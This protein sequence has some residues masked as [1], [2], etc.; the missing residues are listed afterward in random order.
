MITPS[1]PPSE[2]NEAFICQRQTLRVFNKWKVRHI[3]WRVLQYK[4]LDVIYEECQHKSDKI[5][6]REPNL[7]LQ[8]HITIIYNYLGCFF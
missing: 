7:H 1:D 5:T 6:N 3:F 8:M 4:G 2:L